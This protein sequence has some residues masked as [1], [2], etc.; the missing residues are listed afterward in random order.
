MALRNLEIEQLQATKDSLKR[1]RI[2]NKKELREQL[3][4][5]RINLYNSKGNQ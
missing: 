1:K 3:E 5:C 4:K 2:D